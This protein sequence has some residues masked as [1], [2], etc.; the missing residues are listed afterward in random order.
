M[1]LRLNRV[2]SL[3][4]TN[5]EHGENKALRL[6]C[7]GETDY[8]RALALHSDTRDDDDVLLTPLSAAIYG[9]DKESAMVLLD[10]GDD[11]NKVDEY[12]W[13][14]LHRAAWKGLQL[15]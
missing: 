5:V 15:R 7:V 14:A 6:P 4:M 1:R 11:P 9:K 13:N 2:P 3:L 8:E 12:G 10:G